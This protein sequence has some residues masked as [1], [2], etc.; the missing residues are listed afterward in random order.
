MLHMLH[1]IRYHDE[2]NPWCAVGLAFINPSTIFI[3]QLSP[4]QLGGYVSK[5]MVL[6]LTLLHHV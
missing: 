5:V 3:G 4:C 2:L 6:K 1:R